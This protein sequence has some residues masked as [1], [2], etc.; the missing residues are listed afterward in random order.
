MVVVGVG[1]LLV[2]MLVVAML[3]VVVDGGMDGVVMV[4][5]LVSKTSKGLKASPSG[6]VFPMTKEVC[7]IQQA[8]L[9][10]WVVKWSP[11]R[12]WLWSRH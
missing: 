9:Y 5:V 12:K 3:V 2:R 11:G 4:E 6:R 1:E 10:P 7:G 8:L